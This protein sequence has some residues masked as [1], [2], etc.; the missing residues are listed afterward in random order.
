MDA[1]RQFKIVVMGETIEADAFAWTRMPNGEE[2]G[3]EA[4]RINPETGK[5]ECY[6]SSY[7]GTLVYDY[8]PTITPNEFMENVEMSR[9]IAEQ[10]RK[11]F[12]KLDQDV[13]AHYG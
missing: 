12:T 4:I 9:N 13:D 3:F 2:L 7:E 1:V 8:N 5:T 6:I 11:K 10:S